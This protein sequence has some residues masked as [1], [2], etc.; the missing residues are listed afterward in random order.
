MASKEKKMLKR[1]GLPL[2]GWAAGA[3]L[4]IAVILL[5]YR[6]VE[7]EREL[8]AAQSEMDS[9]M[10][11]GVKAKSEAT[12][13]GKSLRLKLD[14]AQREIQRL[15]EAAAKAEGRASEHESQ[16]TNLRQGRASCEEFF[17]GWDVKA[18]P[19]NVVTLFGIARE[20][21]AATDCINKG[22]AATACRHWEGLL[23]QIDRI[24]SPV[25]ESRVEI[26]RLMR[27]HRCKTF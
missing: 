26:E 14:N 5:G 16:I 24:G 1:T 27:Q 17:D 25:S 3:V 9:A 12:D 22:D 8:K 7:A 11:A 10:E 18:S 21:T 2:W 15:N 4:V 13:E 23:V 19:A 20:A 6:T